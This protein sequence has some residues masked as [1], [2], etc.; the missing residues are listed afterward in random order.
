MKLVILSR[1]RTLYSTRRLVEASRRRGHDVR[2]IDPCRCSIHL[3]P[4]SLEVTFDGRSLRHIDCVLPRVGSA[5]AD[6]VINLLNQLDRLG[7][8]C[9]NSGDGVQ[10]SRD[11]FRSLQDLALAPP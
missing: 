2:V 9:L 3:D 8:V 1:S 5:S 11:K 4:S 6:M 7:V 10:R